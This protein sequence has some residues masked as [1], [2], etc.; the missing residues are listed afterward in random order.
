[1]DRR[2]FFRKAAG[3]AAGSIGATSLLPSSRG[4]GAEPETEG[5]SEQLALQ[6]QRALRWAGPDPADWVRPRAAAD[7]NVV[8]V[9]GGQSGLG[10]A[11]GLR[12]KGIGHVDIIDQ[13]NPGQAGI[14]RTIARMRQLRTPKTLI[15]PEQGNPALGIRAWYETLHGQAA[16]ERLDR[17]PRLV[18][19]DYLT[20]FSQV[21]DA[22]V[23]YRTCLLDIEPAGD[24]LR[25]HLES[26][27]GRRT[28]TTHKLVL[29]NG[30]AGAGG[31]NVPGFIRTLPTR[32]WAHT[33]SPIQFDTLAGKVVGVLGAGASAFDAAATALESG[34]AE[35][36]LFSRRA[37]VDYPPTPS[38]SA[39][40]P[41]TDR[42]HANVYEL[43]YELPDEVRWRNHL[44]RERRVESVPLDSIE[45]AVGFKNFNLHLN[46]P[47]TEVAVRDD[48][49]VVATVNG[50]R[51]PFDHVI[52]ATGYAVDLSTQPELASIHTA[53]ALW[54][55]RFHPGP[56][57]DDG[58]AGKYPYL[59]SGFEFL[60]RPGTNADFLRN[61]H[62][63]NLAATLSFG[64][65]VGDIPSAVD[66]PRLVAAIERDL[67]VADVNVAAHKRY[68]D[69]PLS[70]PDLGPYQSAVR[71]G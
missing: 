46:S 45:R 15:G 20:W 52:A 8:I 70:A 13:S 23:R 34:A 12:R 24:L 1:M 19:A 56:G 2:Q 59:G 25:L 62:C 17:I 26:G 16:F 14:W 32:A 51:R 27:D 28:E 5:V 58:A 31:P 64:L 22:K 69:A 65:P 66:Y 6:T 48:G 53:I 3:V 39:A 49:K 11:Y 50:K 71:E 54:S 40:A 10:I 9:G 60:P 61:I 35:V 4:L 57:E 7:H 55:D 37:Y 38:Q 68:V 44:L 29:A 63:F 41:A 30:Y 18:W 43:L 67:F 36:H 42:G 21:T 47:W 33:A